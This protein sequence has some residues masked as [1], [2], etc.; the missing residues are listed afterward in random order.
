MHGLHLTADLYDCEGASQLLVCAQALG[1]LCRAQIRAARLTQ[2]GE[3]WVSFPASEG[4]PGGVTGT[5]L[6]AESHLAVHTWP[7]LGHATLD[8]YVCNFSCDNTARAEQL[9]ARITAA[10]APRRTLVNRLCRGTLAAPNGNSP[11]TG[12]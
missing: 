2:V 1:E 9:L 12:A 10:F 6:L 3:T 4:R 11:G 8:V 7:E 5:V